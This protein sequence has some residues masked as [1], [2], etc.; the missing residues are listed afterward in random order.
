MADDRA[1]GKSF[2]IPDGFDGTNFI[3]GNIGCVLMKKNDIVCPACGK[4]LAQETRHGYAKVVK[5]RGRH[6]PESAALAVVLFC[7][8]KKA[9]EKKSLTLNE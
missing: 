3:V 2:V 5:N 6:I 7:C 9:W 8:G 1:T 4:V